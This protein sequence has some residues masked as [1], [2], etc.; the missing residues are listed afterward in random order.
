MAQNLKEIWQIVFLWRNAASILLKTSTVANETK[1]NDFRVGIKEK[2]V[3]S[4]LQKAFQIIKLCIQAEPLIST[5]RPKQ[6]REQ[7]NWRDL[8]LSVYPHPQGGILEKIGSHYFS[9]H[10][11]SKQLNEAVRKI[12]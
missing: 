11:V 7:L 10:C 12:S 9:G 3:K 4:T 5:R 8:L 6:W 1:M 2:K